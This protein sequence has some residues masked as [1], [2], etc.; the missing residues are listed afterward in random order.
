MSRPA[1]KSMANKSKHPTAN[2]SR[3]A[4]FTHKKPS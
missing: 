4:K 2:R 3:D 1:Y